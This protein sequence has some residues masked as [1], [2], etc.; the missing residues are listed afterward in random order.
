MRH[1]QM[2]RR[3]WHVGWW[4]RHQW[5]HWEQPA[6]VDGRFAAEIVT[7]AAAAARAHVDAA[8][9]RLWWARRRRDEAPTWRHFWRDGA[10]VQ[11]PP[12][13]DCGG[14]VA[15]A[16]LVARALGLSGPSGQRAHRR[17]RH[18]LHPAQTAALS[19]RRGRGAEASFPG[20]AGHTRLP[21]RQCDAVVLV[22]PGGGGAGASALVQRALAGALGLGPPRPDR[23]GR[24]RH[25]GDWPAARRGAPIGGSRADGSAGCARC[26]GLGGGIHCGRGG[27][28]AAGNLAA[29]V[30]A[31]ARRFRGAAS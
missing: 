28:R 13:G 27:L 6:W 30:C 22:Q 2:W 15:L 17:D 19:N 18:H 29:G 20:L 1:R 5:R 16:R 8:F 23:G 21:S 7:Q 4:R 3:Q 26:M 12:H 31:I 9:G 10:T 14:R 25:G 24:G 11:A